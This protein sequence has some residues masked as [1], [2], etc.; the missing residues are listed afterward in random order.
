M[1]DLFLT[2]VFLVILMSL[3]FDFTNGFHDTANVVAASLATKALKP[4]FAILLAV[5]MNFL[6]A[7]VFNKIAQTIASSIVNPQLL[8]NNTRIIIPVLFTAIAWNLITW[9]FGLPSSSAHAL[10]GALTGAVIATIGP[11]AINYKDITVILK[12]L[13]FSPLIAFLTGFFLMIFCRVILF[14]LKPKE[15]NK[16]FFWF[17][18]FSVIGQA[19]AHGANDAQKTMGIIV[20]ALVAEG[21]QQTLQT[22]WEVRIVVAV[23]LAL[24]T[25]TGGWKI[26]NTVSKKITRIEPAS[27]FIADFSSALVISGAT[28]LGLPVSTTHITSMSIAG[29]GTS[30]GFTAVNWYTVLKLILVW[31]TTLPVT[32]FLG[33]ITTKLIF[34]IF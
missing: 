25:A 10:V 14:Y 18:R 29:T 17:Q 27:G 11:A 32:V 5:T 4:R 15:V 2:P 1:S 31:S 30:K 16:Y 6:G 19:F 22:P 23:V 28:F 21:Y 13:F 3:V 7:L 12:S 24:G 33:A 8:Q 20:L 9:F 26:I 34:F